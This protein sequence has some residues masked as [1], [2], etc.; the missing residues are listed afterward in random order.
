[1]PL[2]ELFASARNGF[3]GLTVTALGLEQRLPVISPTKI[4]SLHEPPSPL[5]IGKLR[6]FG[7]TDG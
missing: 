6:D 7:W 5:A 1:M 2:V 3:G 4:Y